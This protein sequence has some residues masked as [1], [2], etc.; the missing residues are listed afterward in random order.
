MG[1][2]D[3]SQRQTDEGETTM[4]YSDDEDDFFGDE[5][6]DDFTSEESEF[7]S[8]PSPEVSSPPVANPEVPS[9]PVAN[10]EVPSPPVANPEVSPVANRPPVTLHFAK[11]K[12]VGCGEMVEGNG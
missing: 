7:E 11:A 6:A 5:F 10:P 3:E 4:A 9:P 8:L 1:N 12:C 2:E